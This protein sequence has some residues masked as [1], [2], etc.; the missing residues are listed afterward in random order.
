MKKKEDISTNE[1]KV[2]VSKFND[3]KEN[4]D[5]NQEEENNAE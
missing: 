1:V 5:N 3:L 2:I 4:L